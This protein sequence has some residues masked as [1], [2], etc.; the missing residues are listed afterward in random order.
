[1]SDKIKSGLDKASAMCEVLVRDGWREYHN[2][3]NKYARCF[4]K[5]LDTQTR[6]HGNLNKL[7]IQVQ[8]SVYNREEHT[9]YELEITAG[10]SDGTWFTLHNYCLP[11]D[12]N[13]GLLLTQRM[14]RAW[15]FVANDLTREPK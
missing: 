2:A 4:H 1:M 6:C 8:C 15:E 5:R 10:L 7:G 9:S 14:L 12:I 3:F 13:Q 11:N